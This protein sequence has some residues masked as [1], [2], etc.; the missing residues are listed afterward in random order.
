MLLKDDNQ[1]NEDPLLD[2]DNDNKPQA[3]IVEQIN[4][5]EWFETN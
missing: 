4:D 1:G 5:E 2:A 3:L